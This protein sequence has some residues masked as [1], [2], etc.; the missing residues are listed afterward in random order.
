ML[1]AGTCITHTLFICLCEHRRHPYEGLLIRTA[2]VGRLSRVTPVVI[3]HLQLVFEASLKYI[4]EK[5]TP[6]RH[7][8]FHYS[9]LYP[10]CT[11]GGKFQVQLAL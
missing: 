2:Y 6:V 5:L 8:H 10:C 9:V 1:D 4:T 3:V 11:T 7:V